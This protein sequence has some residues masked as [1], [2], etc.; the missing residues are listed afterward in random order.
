MF[1]VEA[2]RRL[3]FAIRD[4]PTVAGHD[5]WLNPLSIE[6]LDFLYMDYKPPHPLD[7]LITPD[8][9]SKY[10]RMFTHL[11]RIMRVE[12]ALSA[13]FRM[14]RSTCRPV[15][16]TLTSSNKL[17]LHF[18]F[19]AQS[20]VANLSQYI[21]HTA[22]NGNFDPFLERL[23]PSTEDLNPPFSDVFALAKAHSALMDDVL[24]ACLLRSSQ[25]AAGDLLR[26]ALE[27]VLEFAVLVGDLKTGRLEEYRAAPLLED[28]SSAFRAKMAALVRSLKT[29]VDVPVGPALVISSRGH[30]RTPTGGIQAVVHL[31]ESLSGWWSNC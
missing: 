9:L 14:C 13:V 3:G 20:F 10:Q 31:L 8:I 26:Q 19:I 5:K 6:A 11:L 22:I 4:L 29:L 2:E 27:L 17:L 21:V 28:L 25:R 16:P 23:S 12:H 30:G 18:R 7:I 1:W 15:F 24:A